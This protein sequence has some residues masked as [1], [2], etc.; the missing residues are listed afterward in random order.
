M[1]ESLYYPRRI[2]TMILTIFPMTPIFM[3]TFFIQ[4][5]PLSERFDVHTADYP[6]ERETATPDLLAAISSALLLGTLK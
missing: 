1:G 4:K 6:L 5:T 2:D 3:N